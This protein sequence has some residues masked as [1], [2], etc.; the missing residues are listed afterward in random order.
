MS[1]ETSPKPLVTYR[2]SPS[3]LPDH[4]NVAYFVGEHEIMNIDLNHGFMAANSHTS[5]CMLLTQVF[6]TPHAH[7]QLLEEARSWISA[8]TLE[9]GRDPGDLL[10]RIRALLEGPTQ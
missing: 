6:V 5:E 1:D 9:T 7:I 3:D 2:T 8:S 10:L 4:T